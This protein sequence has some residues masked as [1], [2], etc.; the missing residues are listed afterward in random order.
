MEFW[1]GIARG[2]ASAGAKAWNAEWGGIYGNSLSA[3]RRTFYRR[4]FMP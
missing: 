4:S 1:I 2:R 3:Y